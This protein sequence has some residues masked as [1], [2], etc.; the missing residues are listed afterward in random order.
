MIIFQIILFENLNQYLIYKTNIF[1]IYI[2]I[3]QNCI[4]SEL[5]LIDKSY[6]NI[7]FNVMSKSM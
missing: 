7:F 3:N 5:F 6:K 2:L 1:T 4:S